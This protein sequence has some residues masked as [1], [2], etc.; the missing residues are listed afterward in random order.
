MLSLQ[1][2]KHFINDPQLSD[3]DAEILRNYYRELAEAVYSEWKRNK[4]EEQTFL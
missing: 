1:Q 2:V 3:K 4:G